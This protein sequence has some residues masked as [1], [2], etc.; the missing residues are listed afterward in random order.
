MS[1]NCIE[2][3]EK[4]LT[5]KMAKK[6]PGAEVLEEVAFINKTLTFGN[7]GHTALI[8]S[9]PVLGK[10]RVGKVVRKFDT[11]VFPTYCPFCGKKIKEEGEEGDKR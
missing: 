1:C 8:L 7:K 9:N 3:I 2:R 5:G 11:Q 4:E 6:Y 10:V